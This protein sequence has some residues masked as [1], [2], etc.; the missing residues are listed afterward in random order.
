MKPLLIL[1][2]PILLSACVWSSGSTPSVEPP[3]SQTQ[4]CREAV[5]LPERDLAAGEVERFWLTDRLSLRECRTR[6]QALVDAIQGGP[7]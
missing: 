7:Q 6:H 5:E 3:P 1:M 4:P 2:L